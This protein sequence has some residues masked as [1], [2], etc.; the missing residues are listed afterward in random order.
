MENAS[1]SFRHGLYAMIGTIIGAGT[2]ALPAAMKSMGILAGS[3]A[4]WLTALV[5]LATHLIYTELVL[6]RKSM[7]KRR[8]PGYLEVAFGP[9][10]KRFGYLTNA[11][12]V[13]GACLAYLVIGGEFL[14]VLAKHAGLPTSILMWQVLFWVGGACVVF[15]GLKLVSK[16]E[17]WMT[18]VKIGLLLLSIGL[19]FW[20]S[21]A[22]LF[23][24]M[25]WPEV[26]PLLGVFLF[27][28][29]GWGVIPEVAA[30][31]KGDKEKTR[32]AVAGGSL[33][34]ALLMWLF[35]IFAYAAIGD[36]LTS[37]T[38][39]LSFGVP[40]SMFWLIPAVGFFAVA[41]PFLSLTQDFKAM[42]HLD[43]GLSKRV[44]W[45]VALGSPL[46]LL[47]LVSRNFLGTVG[48][49]GAGVSSVN[50]ILMC[51]AAIKLMRGEKDISYAWRVVVP[52]IC[53]AVFSVVVVRAYLF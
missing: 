3:I 18:V 26:L 30:I 32:L 40:A 16:V 37:N 49:V 48:F 15:V 34:A 22:T 45:A 13:I 1:R 6:H 19:F 14:S 38:G 44:A 35:G 28:L 10:A 41:T 9:W 8:F 12:Q 7:A 27:S 29:F 17:A 21:D 20:K 46:V 47:L 23:F 39:D 2:F 52:G 5:V 31:C 25:N 50:G 53:I 42:L 51:S 11:A 36:S 33:A 4:F 43:A 24:E